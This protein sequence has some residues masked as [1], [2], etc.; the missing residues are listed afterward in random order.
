MSFDPDTIVLDEEEQ[1]IED[2]LEEF[3][4]CKNQEE[5]RG[6]L[7]E[8]AHNK[9]EEL[10]YAKKQISINVDGKVISYFKSLSA[11]TGVAY[12]SLI[13]MF[14]LQCVNERKRP[15]FA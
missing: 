15:V 13:N 2:H 1:W 4:P 11:E 7:V 10:R 8:A 3:R 6:R 9:M 14:L 12:Q 5:L